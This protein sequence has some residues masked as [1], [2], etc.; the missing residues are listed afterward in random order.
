[1]VS[2]LGSNLLAIYSDASSVS[3][4][5]GIGVGL[6]VRDYLQQGAEVH[7]DTTNLGKGQIVYNGELEG[8]TR[9]FEYAADVATPGQEIRIHADNQAAIHRLKGPSDNPGQAWQLRCFKAA[10]R[11]MSKNATVSLH[12]VPGHEDIE[13]NERA[14]QL[15]KAAAIMRLRNRTLHLHVVKPGNLTP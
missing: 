12:W 14:D 9:A 4:G 5:K 6:S 8:I 11:I 10:R 15:A 13:G 2:R 7:S 3:K 1:M